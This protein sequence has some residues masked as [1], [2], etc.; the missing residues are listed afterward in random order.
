MRTWVALLRGI[1][2]GTAKR[3]A[4]ADLRDLL[5][6]LGHGDVRTLL[7]SG[8]AVFTAAGNEASVAAGVE[9]AIERDLGMSVRVILRSAAELADLV[10]DNP[11]LAEGLDPKWLAV[12]FLDA[13]P[14]AAAWSRLEPDA[15]RPDRMARGRRLVH[16]YQPNGFA[17]STLPDLGK[18]LGVTNT[19][20]NWNTV[21]KLAS[22][23]TDG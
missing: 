1:N 9:S 10:G 11:F 15:H 21:T 4:M 2:V 19:A 16:L 5:A 6:A 18:L 12:A 7:N 20:R 22:L 3:M 8:N 14:S 23:A 17:G 13:E